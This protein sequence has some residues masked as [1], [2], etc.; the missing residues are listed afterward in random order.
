MKRFGLKHAMDSI[1]GEVAN[2]NLLRRVSVVNAQM[3]RHG[4]VSSS[5]G[6]IEGRRLFIITIDNQYRLA[7]IRTEVSTV[8]A[9]SLVVFC[10]L[11]MVCG[12][13]MGVIWWVF[14]INPNRSYS[15][16]PTI[17]DCSSIGRSQLYVKKTHMLHQLMTNKIP[18]SE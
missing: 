17:T 14:H 6:L 4:V 1:P 7:C 3:T 2:L 12:S 15:G 10:W 5:T 13:M 9:A 18:P 8:I 11:L 16:S